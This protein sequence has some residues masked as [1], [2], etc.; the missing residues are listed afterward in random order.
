MGRLQPQ[1]PHDDL[2]IGR[3]PA[4]QHHQ[5]IARRLG[6][7]YRSIPQGSAEPPGGGEPRSFRDTRR[8]CQAG[9]R[10]GDG[11]GPRSSEPVDEGSRRAEPF[12]RLTR[13][14]AGG[15]GSSRDGT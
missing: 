3:A 5:G 8:P 15:A 6:D 4:F 13:A 10:R 1:L 12:R 2:R 14:T 7:V 9:P 11:G